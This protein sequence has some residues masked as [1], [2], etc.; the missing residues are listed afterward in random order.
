MQFV[1]YIIAKAKAV[2]KGTNNTA[3]KFLSESSMSHSEVHW[4]LSHLDSL[5][6]LIEEWKELLYIVGENVNCYSYW[7]KQHEEP[8]KNSR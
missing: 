7:G 4:L 5:L 3:C 8:S 6:V 2:P 1:A